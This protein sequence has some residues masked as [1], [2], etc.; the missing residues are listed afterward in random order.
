M[1]IKDNKLPEFLKK[2][3]MSDKRFINRL[4]AENNQEGVLIS[5][6]RQMAFELDAKKIKFKCERYCKPTRMV[7]RLLE[8]SETN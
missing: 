6:I 1:A 3:N 8:N 4:L 5:Q 7:N 2:I